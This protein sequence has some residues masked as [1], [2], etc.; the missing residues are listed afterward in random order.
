MVKLKQPELLCV[1]GRDNP[2][3]QKEPFSVAPSRPTNRLSSGPPALQT[4]GQEPRQEW[5]YS[6]EILVEYTS[7][8]V[9][10]V[11]FT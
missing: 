11:K 9:S 2:T 6:V 7:A 8:G 10:W 4:T 1:K 5:V 3:R